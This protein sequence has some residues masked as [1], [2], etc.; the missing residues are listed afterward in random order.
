[1]SKYALYYTFNKNI[2]TK[3][4][5]SSQKKTFLS[6]VKSLDDESKRVL[7]SLILEHATF[8]EMEIKNKLP[9]GCK[10]K[11][12]TVTIDLDKLPLELRWILFKFLNVVDKD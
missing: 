11:Q 5:S 1:M 12:D 4:L 3:D 7:I 6:K 8:N 9:F 10:T 2:P